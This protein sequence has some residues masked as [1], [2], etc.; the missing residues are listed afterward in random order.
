[1]SDISSNFTQIKEL[2]N[3]TL[4]T[5]APSRSKNGVII[6]NHLMFIVGLAIGITN[7]ILVLGF[8]KK[9]EL[10]KTS[11]V[12]LS[13]LGISDVLFGFTFASRVFGEQYF[14]LGAVYCRVTLGL[15][16]ASSVM[17]GICILLLSLQVSI[18]RGALPQFLSG[19]CGTENFYHTLF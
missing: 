18:M 7:I 8:T 14:D 4:E 15:I 19:L 17:S 3:C 13:N 1:M 11:F 9:K 2:I 5:N 10:T 6:V 12:F 16:M